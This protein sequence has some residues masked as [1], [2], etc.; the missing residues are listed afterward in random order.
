MAFPDTPLGTTVELGIGGVWTDIT[1]D[2]HLP[3]RVVIRSAQAGTVSPGS[4]TLTL[5]NLDG[6]YSPRNP[7]SPYYGVIGRNTQGVRVM[8]LDEGDLLVDVARV[9]R[10]DEDGTEEATDDETVAPAESAG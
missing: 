5:N 8:H 9:V 4:C 2:V 1:R 3:D 7:L 6:R 10:E